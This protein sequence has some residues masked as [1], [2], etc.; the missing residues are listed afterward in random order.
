[1]KKFIKTHSIKMIVAILV[2]TSVIIGLSYII[3]ESRAVNNIINVTYKPGNGTGEEI[4]VQQVVS[5]KQSQGTSDYT[6]NKIVFLRNEATTPDGKTLSFNGG[7][8]VYN[9]KTYEMVLT[10]WKLTAVHKNGTKITEFVAPE[11]ENYSNPDDAA[12]DIDRIYAQEGWYI[13]PNGVTAI[14]VTAVYG[15]A[16]YA[17]SPNRPNITLLT[18][19]PTLPMIWKLHKN[20]NMVTAIAMHAYRIPFPPSGVR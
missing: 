6:D 10:G 9:D 2:V 20:N 18:A 8:T 11:H 7:T 1:M 17:R 15:R 13:V 14:E 5:D 12:K 3:P 16:I 19:S 4:T